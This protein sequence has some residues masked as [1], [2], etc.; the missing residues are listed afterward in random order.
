MEGYAGGVG[1]GKAFKLVYHIYINVGAQDTNCKD[2]MRTT[3]TSQKRQCDTQIELHKNLIQIYIYSV[4]SCDCR[5]ILLQVTI[6][7][8]HKYSLVA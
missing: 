6:A 2:G 4:S 1:L 5:C 8:L 3:Q 7:D